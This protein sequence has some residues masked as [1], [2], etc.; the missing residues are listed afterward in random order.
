MTTEH[1]SRLW[2]P[3]ADMGTV[4][5]RELIIDRGEDVW[6]WDSEGNRYLDGTA[7]LW[8][9]NIG[10]GREEVVDAVAA[11]MRRLEAYSCFGDF[12]NPP[13][14]ELA[15]RLAALAPMD[16]ARVFFGS[17]GGDGIDTAVKLARRYFAELGE[18]ERHHVISRMHGYHGTHGYGT[19]LAGIEPNRAGFGPLHPEISQVPH[20]SLDALRAGFERVGPERVS[21]VFVE[22]VIGAGGVYPPP[23]GYIE[24]VAAL[25]R[26][27]GALFV[28][29]AVICGFGRL[30][31]WFGVE[32]FGVEPDIIVFAKG[33][34]SGYQPL[35]GIVAS[36][37][38]AEPFFA[39]PGAPVFRHGATY[40]G[41]PAACAAGL[42]N[43][44]IMEREGLVTRGQELEGELLAAL[45]PLAGHPAVSEVRGGCGTM[46]AV[47]LTPEARAE[48][49]TAVP[50]VAAGAR[51]AG[52]L[53]RP[54]PTAVATSPP[55]TAT[56][57]H[58]KLI[59][60][61]MRAGLDRLG[62]GAAPRTREGA[63]A[64]P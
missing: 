49:P 40:A 60:D 47:E 59:A 54:L 41:H 20:D 38:V 19:A 53:V 29:D 42:A 64:R 21:A 43:I 16:D 1:D 36:G 6:V 31:S 56:P 32:R 17:G 63:A 45:E 13:A 50:D 25:C 62:A 3:F 61:A 52:V 58:F 23:D 26:E 34:T 7:S 27:H 39:A 24:G 9:A 5:H 8:Y 18:P 37:R 35:G 57:E 2:H 44:A 4:R 55:L 22:P 48:R 11:Q 12:A 28:A 33:V 15:E 46:A 10:H 30:G 51:A 14:L